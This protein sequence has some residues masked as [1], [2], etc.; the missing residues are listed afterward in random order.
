MLRLLLSALVAIATATNA[1]GV[2][3]LAENAKKEGVVS[4]A[5]GLQY[6]IL[7]AGT[8]D[9]HPTVRSPCECHYEGRSA[10][11][12]PD[13]PVFDSSYARGQP[14]TFAP[15]QGAGAAEHLSRAHAQLPRC[16]PS[17]L[18]SQSLGDGRRRCSS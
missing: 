15:N 5:S 8:G 2:A 1:A 10:S 9:S 6:K 3:F 11:N 18:R 14:A 16:S 7:K 4:L 17:D 12:Y 13:G